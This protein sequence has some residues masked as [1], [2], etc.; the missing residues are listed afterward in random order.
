MYE[1]NS[2]KLKIKVG[3]QIFNAKFLFPTFLFVVRRAAVQ[4]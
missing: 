3:Q 2:Y 1:E 4:N